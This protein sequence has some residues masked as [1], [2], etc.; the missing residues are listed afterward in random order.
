MTPRQLHTVI[1]AAAEGKK[2]NPFEKG[3]G[4]GP[5]GL[6]LTPGGSTDKGPAAGAL[7]HLPGLTFS[8]PR[9]SQLPQPL[10]WKRVYMFSPQAGVTG[11]T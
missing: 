9:R 10:L 2:S 7:G 6:G 8:L 5:T 4:W 1:S 3:V 11:E